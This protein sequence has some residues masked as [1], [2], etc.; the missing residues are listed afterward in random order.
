MNYINTN[1]LNSSEISWQQVYWLLLIKQGEEVE[2]MSA[3][4]DLIDLKM[5][6]LVKA[7]NKSES[8][9]SRLRLDT[10]GKKFLEKLGE[11]EIS[12]EHQRV[13][14]WMCQIY[15]DLGKKVGNKTKLTRHIRDFSNITG[16]SRNRLVHLCQEL[17]ND[18][19][20]MEFS[21]VLEFIF[22]KAP[23]AFATRFSLEN[24]RLWKYYQ[25][26]QGYFDK[27]WEKEKY[28]N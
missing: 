1:F 9:L 28:Q 22:W 24:S 12:E 17:T 10:E 13:A 4:S 20:Q 16:I 26:R 7:K 23:N 25:D 2:N 8:D 14:D 5:V 15:L 11:S 6:K 21:H 18:S 3:V 27:E 19:E